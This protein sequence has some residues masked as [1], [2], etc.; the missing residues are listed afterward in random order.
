MTKKWKISYLNDGAML[1][2]FSPIDIRKKSSS[3]LLTLLFMIR[4]IRLISQIENCKSKYFFQHYCY[5]NRS[6][7]STVSCE[8]DKAERKLGVN[9]SH[10]IK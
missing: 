2:D 10:K 1:L 9:K 7:K 3:V 6:P 5:L 8:V 4:K